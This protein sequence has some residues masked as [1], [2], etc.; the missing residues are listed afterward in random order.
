MKAMKNQMFPKIKSD[1]MEMIAIFEE[2]EK[3]KSKDGNSTPSKKPK[4]EKPK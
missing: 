4:T 2:E 1:E 3:K